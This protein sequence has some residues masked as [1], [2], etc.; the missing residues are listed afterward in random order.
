[1]VGRNHIPVR[2]ERVV[3]GVDTAA[4]ARG[5][6]AGSR[7]DS[8]EVGPIVEVLVP[9]VKRAR[10]CY[11]D[12]V[13]ATVRP[14]PEVPV[15]PVHLIVVAVVGADDDLLRSDPARRSALAE[16]EI[17]T[18]GK[19]PGWGRSG[20]ASLRTGGG[21]AAPATGTMEIMRN[22][23]TAARTEKCR[24]IDSSLSRTRERIVSASFLV[25]LL[26]RS[27]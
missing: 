1:V 7:T 2:P 18:L 22:T 5:A 9:D 26:A 3:V 8:V 12:D 16:R 23:R 27:C 6:C 17:D 10:Q 25:W 24:R 11:F 15:T 4:D 20:L 13:G 14:A 21:G 19:V